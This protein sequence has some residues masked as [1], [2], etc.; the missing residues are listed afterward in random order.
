MQLSAYNAVLLKAQ[1]ADYI[2]LGTAE[3]VAQ[4]SAQ[5]R[6]ALVQPGALYSAAVCAMCSARGAVR[7]L[8]SAVLSLQCQC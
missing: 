8:Q 4:L 3:C 2:A 5:T 7:M 1:C 6:S